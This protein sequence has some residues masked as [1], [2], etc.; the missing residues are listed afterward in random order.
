MYIRIKAIMMRHS[1][2]RRMLRLSISPTSP[3]REVANR[4]I[5]QRKPFARISPVASCEVKL[6]LHIAPCFVNPRR[7]GVCD[8]PLDKIP[9]R[10]IITTQCRYYRFEVVFLAAC[11]ATEKHDKLYHSRAAAMV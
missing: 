6:I 9:A 11:A 4:H 7:P 2:K 5:Q 10:G 1:R 8:T 3:H